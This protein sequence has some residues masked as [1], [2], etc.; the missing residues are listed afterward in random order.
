MQ[1]L[2]S[3]LF[4]LKGYWQFTLEGFQKNSAS[5]T[6]LEDEIA[7]RIAAS[8]SSSNTQTQQ[9]QLLQDKVMMVTGANSGLGFE[10]AKQLAKLQATVHLVCRS[11][12]RGEAAIAQIRDYCNNNNNSNKGKLFL[13]IVDLSDLAAVKQFAQT[14][15]AQNTALHVLVNN[16]GALPADRL[17]NTQGLNYTFALNTMSGHVLTRALQPLLQKT[18]TISEPARVITVSSGGMYTV[19]LSVDDFNFVKMEPFV[20]ERA[21]AQTKRQQVVLNRLY[22][23]KAA[24]AKHSVVYFS[25]HPGW[26]DTPGVQSSLPNFYNSMKASLRTAEQGS[27]TIVWLAAAASSKLESGKFYFDRQVTNEHLTCA[28]TQESEQDSQALWQYC[29]NL[30]SK[31]WNI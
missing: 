26:C 2:R 29:E 12:E 28:W 31:Y 21:Y 23:Q 15:A 18:G 8:N 20:G 16:A 1:Y 4:G 9:Q 13:H 30:Y 6:P 11:K 19:P 22:A 5:F 3:T 17:T 14:F 27:D 10:T 25:M 24:E 7:T